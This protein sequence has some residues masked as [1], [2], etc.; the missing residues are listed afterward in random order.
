[1]RSLLMTYWTGSFGSFALENKMKK[2]RLSHLSFV[3]SIIALAV[4]VMT[5][6]KTGGISDIRNQVSILRDDMREWKSQ[7][8]NRMESKSLLFD[9]VN[10]LT[11]SIDSLKSGNGVESKKLIDK[12]VK[13]ILSVEEK[14][15]E[16]KKEQLGKIR[17]EIERLSEEMETKDIK[18]MK[19]LEYQVILLRI[20]EEN[21]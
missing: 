15:T 3:I 1:V 13:T 4:A 11:A 14:L 7:A 10:N 19:D 21:L 9:A 12:A 2:I 16:R 18:V 8:E 5:F 17:S 20:F 6:L